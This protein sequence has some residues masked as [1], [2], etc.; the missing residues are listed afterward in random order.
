MCQY[1]WFYLNFIQ[2][3]IPPQFKASMSLFYQWGLTLGTFRP[4][5]ARRQKM[6]SLLAELKRSNICWEHWL[7][8]WDLSSLIG[9]PLWLAGDLCCIS[10]KVSTFSHL[11]LLYQKVMLCCSTLQLSL[12]TPLEFSKFDSVSCAQHL[13]VNEPLRRFLTCSKWANSSGCSVK[14]CPH[15]LPTTSQHEDGILVQIVVSSSAN[16]YA[17]VS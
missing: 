12:K 14:N 8:W 5:A 15:I 3:K 10:S 6:L 13:S 2:I 16:E 9:F 4:R 1:S 7:V 11:V 17:N